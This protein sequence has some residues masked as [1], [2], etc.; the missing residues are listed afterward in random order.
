MYGVNG[1]DTQKYKTNCTNI[2]PF[3]EGIL[4][5][6]KMYARF[7]YATGVMR[8]GVRHLLKD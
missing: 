4:Q 3:G 8:R 6:G 1:A 7:V 2:L 5:W